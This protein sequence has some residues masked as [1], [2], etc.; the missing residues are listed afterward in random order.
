M[1]L[2]QEAHDSFLAS[3]NAS[4][5]SL[6]DSATN[7]NSLLEEVKNLEKKHRDESATRN[8]IQRINPFIRGVEQYG[9]AFD[10][11]TNAKPEILSLLWGGA[12]I[13]LHV[14]CS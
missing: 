7:P 2:F 3:L 11:I 1:E 5:K 6:V 4:E 14:S 12:R 9:K 13:L 8:L 10:V